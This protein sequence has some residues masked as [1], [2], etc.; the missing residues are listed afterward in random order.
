VGSFRA[1]DAARAAVDDINQL[2]DQSGRRLLYVDQL[3][4]SAGSITANIREAYGRRKG[5]ERN[6]YLRVARSSAEETD[7]HMRGNWA[8]DRVPPKRFWRIHHRLRVVVKMLN[9]LMGN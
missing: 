1:L 9:A 8:A 6:Q 2:L 5:P 3:R 7:E 4:E